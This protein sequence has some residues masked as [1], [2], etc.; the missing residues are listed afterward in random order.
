MAQTTHASLIP[1]L[2]HDFK[3]TT[4]EMTFKYLTYQS[5]IHIQL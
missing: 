4:K 5:Q 3:A 1:R 2:Y